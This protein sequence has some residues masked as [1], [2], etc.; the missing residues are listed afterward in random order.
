MIVF[1]S[2]VWYNLLVKV[3]RN[4]FEAI[5]SLGR[6]KVLVS[7]VY[8][9][10]NPRLAFYQDDIFGGLK[11]GKYKNDHDLGYSV[12]D[13]YISEFGIDL[14]KK[15]ETDPIYH[16]LGL[17][18]SE[19]FI[20]S[21]DDLLRTLEKLGDDTKDLSV[22]DKGPIDFARTSVKILSSFSSSFDFLVFSSFEA[23]RS[24]D[25]ERDLE[26]LMISGVYEGENI[27]DFSGFWSNVLF[28]KSESYEKFLS[29]FD[30]DFR[31]YVLGSIT[32][33][34]E[35]GGEEE[36]K[37]FSL[38]FGRFRFSE[39]TRFLLFDTSDLGRKIG[40][41]SIDQRLSSS[42]ISGWFTRLLFSRRDDF[43]E[44]KII[45][46]IDLYYH[47]VPDLKDVVLIPVELDV[48]GRKILVLHTF[49]VGDLLDDY[50]KFYVDVRDRSPLY[51]D[52][53]LRLYPNKG[54]EG[55][56]KF[57]LEAVERVGL[58]IDG[59][60][61]VNL[62]ATV[63]FNNT[64]VG[65]LTEVEG[66]KELV[67]RGSTPKY[68]SLDISV[69]GFSMSMD[70]KLDL[71]ASSSY[72]EELLSLVRHRN[73]YILKGRIWNN[74]R[75][76]SLIRNGIER[77][78]SKFLSSLPSSC[79]LS[80]EEE[81]NLSLRDKEFLFKMTDFVFRISIK[82]IKDKFNK[83]VENGEKCDD[84]RVYIDVDEEKYG[85]DTIFINKIKY[86][87]GPKFIY[88]RVDPKQSEDYLK[89]IFEK[90]TLYSRFAYFFDESSVKLCFENSKGDKVEIDID[91][92]LH[93]DRVKD[94]LKRKSYLG[95]INWSLRNLEE[96]R[97]DQADMY[98]VFLDL[99]PYDPG[100]VIFLHSKG[101][102]DDIS[103]RLKK[104]L[105]LEEALE[106]GTVEIKIFLD[107]GI[108]AKEKENKICILPE[109]GPSFIKNL[110]LPSTFIYKQ[111][112]TVL[113]IEDWEDIVEV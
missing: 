9:L 70:E 100:S 105:R 92:P 60:D 14:P 65:E 3:F 85:K 103:S 10:F 1:P 38:P 96:I 27:P 72:E 46:C 91:L 69:Y 64:S 12:L 104:F 24:R 78:E 61:G 56:G 86:L 15:E 45:G 79:L 107:L 63:S 32:F 80:S 67:P 110:T 8:H 73:S 97:K 108:K 90:R 113:E 98:S 36:T 22:L 76:A 83:C 18:S 71:S 57:V 84:F 31:K 25:L 88:T 2:N 42:G 94:S 41:V 53:I 82:A 58:E 49:L 44:P 101:I 74:K 39:D 106:Q 48:G 5:S 50:F 7:N 37:Y 87:P 6:G 95:F 35:K 93:E 13:Q 28:G 51:T 26:N 75:F 43:P 102:Y 112:E 21:S 109:E 62:S 55:G 17:I 23:G 111:G 29:V 33:Y 68:N 54:R 16:K 19:S 30:E 66:S 11:L 89:E 4:L 34:D 20:V 40:L 59:L 52:Y 77:F 81:R 99:V 47:S